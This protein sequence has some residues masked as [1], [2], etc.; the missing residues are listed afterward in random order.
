MISVLKLI[1]KLKRLN[2]IKNKI[3]VNTKIIQLL[4]KCIGRFV[5]FIVLFCVTADQ[6][7]PETQSLCIE[8]IRFHRLTMKHVMLLTYKEIVRLKLSAVHNA[9]DGDRQVVV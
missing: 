4:T 2:Y 3:K 5:Q 1:L 7:L 8:T 9:V 6:S